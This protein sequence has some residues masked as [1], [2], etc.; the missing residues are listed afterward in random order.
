MLYKVI[1]N[2][3]DFFKIHNKIASKN[4]NINEDE[5]EF[6]VELGAYNII[7]ESGYKYKLKESLYTKIKIFMKTY[8]YL[9]IGVLFLFSLLYINS[10]RVSKIIFNINTPINNEIKQEIESNYKKLFNFN[11]ADIN[12]T[13]LSNKLQ[14]KYLEY[15]Y[16]AVY[17]S[18]NDIKV[19]IY[20]EDKY[21]TLSANEYGNI[22]AK[23]DSVVD[24]F[25]IY[26]GV[27]QLYKNKFVREGD[28]LISATG[29]MGGLGLVIGNVYE[30]INIEIKKK[31]TIIE[32]TE[33]KDNYGK[34]S[35]FGNDFFLNKDN[36]Y[37]E[38]NI[39]ERVVFNFFDIFKIKQIE[40][41]EKNAII[42]EYEKE[43]A[44]IKAK[45]IIINNF[46]D[47]KISD[48]EKIID[49]YEYNYYQNE[50][51]HNFTFI[52]KKLESIGTLATI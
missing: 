6:E 34:I 39:N 44:L 21:P 25:Y 45:N 17:S 49:I 35:L 29:N 8:Y 50:E 43:D 46:E 33:N 1:M 16:I 18:N 30:K 41:I 48:L 10:Y 23:K 37:N 47:N 3:N 15:P 52:I 19:D 26:S 40:E 14:K 2:K 11:F 22:I 38:S 51:S 20:R 13:S 7:K 12:Y 4:L 31:E 36:N 5:A 27:G 9:I 28:I 32:E 42:K 24:T